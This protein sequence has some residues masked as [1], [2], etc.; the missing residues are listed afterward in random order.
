MRYL[1]PFHPKRHPH[2]FTDILVIGG[3]L[4]GLRTALA[5]DPKFQVVL[6]SIRRQEAALLL[7][8]SATA[9]SRNGAF[10]RY[11]GTFFLLK[12]NFSQFYQIFSFFLDIR[13]ESR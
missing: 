1:V 13:R 5:V 9:Q 10:Y 12:T 8:Q 11:L 3:G 7:S 6:L 2:F 4:A